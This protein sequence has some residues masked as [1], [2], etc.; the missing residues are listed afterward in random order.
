MLSS[1]CRVVGF[2]PRINHLL[3]KYPFTRNAIKSL[4]KTRSPASYAGQK[5][6]M[7]NDLNSAYLYRPMGDE[8]IIAGAL[9]MQVEPCA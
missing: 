2:H 9:V 7:Q 3:A 1:I 8:F 6:K 4:K 5:H